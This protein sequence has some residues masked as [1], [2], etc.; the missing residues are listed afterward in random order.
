[1][2]LKNKAIIFSI[3]LLSAIT[4]FISDSFAA[5][6]TVTAETVRMR[7]EPTTKSSIV[8]N[9]DKN[10]EV[11]VLGEEDGWYKVKY[12]GENGY[13]SA[14]Y[15]KVSGEIASSTSDQNTGNT[16]NDENNTS[17]EDINT[18]DEEN[19]TTSTGSEDENNVAET[20]NLEVEVDQEYTINKN[21][22]L[23]ILPLVS[24]IK[25]G[26]VNASSKVR[27]KEVTNLWAY[28][29]C[30]LGDGWIVKEV[31]NNNNN[32]TSSSNETSSN[33]E[34]A[35]SKETPEDKEE[36]PETSTSSQK[37]KIG[38][39]NVENV[40]VRKGPSTDSE[41]IGSLELNDKVKILDEENNWYKVEYEDEDGYIAKKLISD[42]KITNT[43]SSRGM[44]QP[45]GTNNILNKE[46]EVNAEENN[47]NT[48][49]SSKTTGAEV[50]EYAK[51]FLGAKYVSGGNGPNAFDCSGFTKYVYNHF[52]Y[53]L[54]RTSIAQA[55]NGVKVEKDELKQ[56]D[57]LIFLN[58]AKTKIGH[59]G[60]YIG[61]D[62]FIHAANATR[63][64]VTDSVNS[65]YY[66]P[67][68]VEARRIL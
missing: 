65:S 56:G 47:E 54:S 28:V 41:P 35:T 60:I 40:Y 27:V 37:N 9:L 36:N 68:F 4:L 66:G 10:D 23:Y 42:E 51:T 34:V 15:L 29:S 48:T 43:T 31:L 20:N 61:G 2:R 30:D 53:S 57:L 8:L 33:N 64:V 45:R 62:R 12:K 26:D 18:V 52:G 7:E 25:L 32:K 3:G 55:N 50:V 5:T 11:E 63:G 44:I 46:N 67:R 1:M 49:S 19:I 59:V 6:G 22:S 39:V 58:D 21:T 13:V 17:K 38:Y 16:D 24:S 14:D